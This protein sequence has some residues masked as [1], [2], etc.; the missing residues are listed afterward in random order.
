[1]YF[2]FQR[3]INVTIIAI[4]TTIFELHFHVNQWTEKYNLLKLSSG[5]ICIEPKL[6]TRPLILCIPVMPT[7][8][9]NDYIKLHLFPGAK[10]HQSNVFLTRAHLLGALWPCPATLTSGSSHWNSSGPRVT[11]QLYVRPS[12]PASIHVSRFARSRGLHILCSS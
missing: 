10:W 9:M 12:P 1:M 4:N 8:W 11:L 2:N 3:S 6:L 7:E 5:M